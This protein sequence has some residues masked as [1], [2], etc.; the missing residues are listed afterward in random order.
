MTDHR[1][2]LKSSSLVS[3]LQCRMA[4]WD[5]NLSAAHLTPTKGT[6]DL[7]SKMKASVTDEEVKQLRKE[8]LNKCFATD[9][10]T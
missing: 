9:N 8:F 1:T 10:S 3:L 6:L 4:M 2:S 5:D 7:A